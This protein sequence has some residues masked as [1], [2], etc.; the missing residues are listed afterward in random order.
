MDDIE[1]AI[2]GIPGRLAAAKGTAEPLRTL[3]TAFVDEQEGKVK[4]LQKIRDTES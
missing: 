3:L 2:R 1:R 4:A